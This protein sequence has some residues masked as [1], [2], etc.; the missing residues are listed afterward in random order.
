MNIIPKNPYLLICN[1]KED[2][3]MRMGPALAGP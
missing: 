1:G 2:A 3:E